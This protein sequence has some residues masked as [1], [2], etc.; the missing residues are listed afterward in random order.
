[1]CEGMVCGGGGR[2]KEEGGRGDGWR[3]GGKAV[4]WGW[5]SI[6]GVGHEDLK[7]RIEEQRLGDQEMGRYVRASLASLGHSG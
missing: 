2:R 6:W 1:M 4:G 5:R 3:G 7:L